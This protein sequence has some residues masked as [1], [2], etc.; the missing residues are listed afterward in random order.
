MSSNKEFEPGTYS[1][2]TFEDAIRMG[3]INTIEEA[4]RRQR[5]ASGKIV[6][7]KDQEGIIVEFQGGSRR[8]F[9]N[10]NELSEHTR[11]TG[12]IIYDKDGKKQYG[13]E[14][15]EEEFERLRQKK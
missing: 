1:A 3:F 12:G 2:K 4:R 15:D 13:Q 5:E 11:A 8:T 10:A 14:I 7:Y 9:I 6:G